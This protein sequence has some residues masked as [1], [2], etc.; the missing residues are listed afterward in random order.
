M[1]R[2][3]TIIAALLSWQYARNV[4]AQIAAELGVYRAASPVKIDGVLDEPCW[5]HASPVR[6]D[7][8]QSQT[9]VISKEPR[10]VV[11]Y[12]WDAH[13]LY[14]AYETFD[15]NLIAAGKDAFQGPKDN[16]RQGC[17]ISEPH[18]VD[19]VEF[20]ISFGDERF[21]WELHHNALNHFNDIWVTVLDPDWPIS[22]S[23]MSLF[24]LFHFA[25][26]E[27]VKDDGQ[28]KLAMATKHKPNARGKPSTVNDPGDEDS[29]YAAEIRFPWV[30]IGAPVKARRK[31]SAW[32][33]R[34]RTVR[35]LAVVSNRD[36]KE[37]YHHSS[38][39]GKVQGWFHKIVP[40]WPVYRMSAEIRPE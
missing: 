14:L 31:D 9:G 7:Y 16:R 5:E 15:K 12:A 30:G 33:M 32:D 17:N 2:L 34:N 25:D 13:Y 36:L 37:T 24:G 21:L 1:R 4:E 20:F 39:T 28:C 40:A 26:E 27:Y 29:G 11:K 6:A 22:R 38:P 3:P 8:R 23:A 10:M 18:N 19:V 35:I